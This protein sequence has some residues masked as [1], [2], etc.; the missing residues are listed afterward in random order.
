MANSE[1]TF[2]LKSAFQLTGRQFFILGE[3]LSGVIKKGMM[4]DLSSIGIE[5]EIMI[6]AIEFA[7]F[8]KDNKVWED[9]SLGVSGLTEEEKEI[10]KTQS[11]FV[12]PITISG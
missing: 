3:I 7:L 10:L 12:L 2:I 6:E 11:P 5:K 8:R 1:A 9:V 4:I